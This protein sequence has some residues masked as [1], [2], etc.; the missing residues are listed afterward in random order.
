MLLNGKLKINKGFTLI[1]L[2]VVIAIIGILAAI[3]LASLN[4]AR[5]KGGD[6]AVRSNIAN[7][8]GQAALYY[9]T[10][11][12]YGNNVACGFTSG[13]TAVGVCTGLFGA[14]STTAQAGLRAAATASGSTAYGFT[15][16]TGDA[17]AIGAILKTTN[18]ISSN[19]GVDYYCVDS[20][21]FG[22]VKDSIP[23]YWTTGFTSCP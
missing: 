23:N 11:I 10:N 7:I 21:G 14:G 17:W 15:N 4:S 16:A 22:G 5:S 6:S 9:D 8:R 19:S 18:I 12:T 2:L 20:T 3:V 1:E 13:G